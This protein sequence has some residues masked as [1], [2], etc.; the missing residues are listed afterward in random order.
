MTGAA[1]VHVGGTLTADDIVALEAAGYAAA[2]NLGGATIADLTMAQAARITLFAQGC[3]S[4]AG[5]LSG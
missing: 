2:V 4:R 5:F 3:V 1:V